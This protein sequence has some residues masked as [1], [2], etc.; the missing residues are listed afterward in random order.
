[1]Q[2]AARKDGMGQKYMSIAAA[3][4]EERSDTV[5]SLPLTSASFLEN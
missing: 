4:M 1:M 5:V 2:C 3:A